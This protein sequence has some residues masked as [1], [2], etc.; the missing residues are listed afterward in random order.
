MRKI[1]LLTSDGI[2]EALSSDFKDVPRFTTIMENMEMD[3]YD[4]LRVINKYSKF[5]DWGE[6]LHF[7]KCR[8]YKATDRCKN[9]SYLKVSSDEPMSDE[10]MCE[11]V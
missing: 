5:L 4:M 11:E 2:K 6:C 1:E 3:Y 7:D 9:V 8:L 10:P